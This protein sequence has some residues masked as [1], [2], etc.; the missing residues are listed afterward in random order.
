MIKLLVVDDSA[1]MRRLLRET[2]EAEG[3]FEV[4]IARDAAEALAQVHRFAPQV[5]T[6]DINMPGMDGLD[7][8][9]RIMVEAP[10][11]VV[12]VSSLTREGAETTLEALKL[13]AVDFVAK[14]EGTVSLSIDRIRPMLVAKVRAAAGARLRQ[15]FRL[16]ERV[17]HRIGGAQGRAAVPAAPRTAAFA[18]AEPS[19]AAPIEGLV[20]IGASTGGPTA[21]ETVLSGL[22]G[23]FP[24]P[25]LV[26]QH[27][28]SGFTAAF[29]RRLDAACALRVVEVASPMP[30]Q[31]GSV[32][33]GRGDADLIVGWR[34][35]ALVAISAPASPSYPW[36]PSVD[37]LVASARTHVEPSRMLGV[38]LTGMGR[39]GAGAMA[40][41]REHG[42]RTIAEDESTAVV[43]GM[44]G[45]LV[46]VGGAEAVLPLP[47]IPATILR[48]VR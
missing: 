36:H 24:W 18:P 26:A 46:R 25:V 4:Q 14:P 33:L 28:P 37:R 47:A 7:C 12:M 2:F 45:E 3:D 19:A 10:R 32:Y 21:L 41:L 39:D 23:D 5:V 11:P 27:M 40:A 43:W 44:P 31:P 29:A 1:L 6:L 48:L 15:S 35:A 38:L 22:P 34:G 42:G 8:L 16:K 17:R 30:V 9:S 20:V 13:G